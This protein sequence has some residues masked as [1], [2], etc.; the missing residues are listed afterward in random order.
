MP[1]FITFE[2]IEGSGKTTQIKLIEQHLLQKNIPCRLTRE[3]GGTDVCNS[4]RKI[5][6]S[7][8][9]KDMSHLCELFLYAANRAE[10]VEK[11]IL[12][13]LNTGKVVLCDR[14]TDATLAYQ[15]YGRGFSLEL[16]E[17]LNKMVTSNLKISKTILLD[18]KPE[19]GLKRALKRISHLSNENKEDRFEQEKLDFHVK[20]RNG[21]LEL[22]KKDPARFAIIDANGSEK[23]IHKQIVTAIDSLL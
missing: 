11:I 10:H 16:I 17:Q 18:L 14:F 5:L 20:I 1:L 22:A 6:L 8:Q 9:N 21:Y 13:A 2:G 3:P 12:P 7:S 4:I 19:E 23:D 15:G